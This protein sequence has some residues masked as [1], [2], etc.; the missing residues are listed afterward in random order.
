MRFEKLDCWPECF[1]SYT[2]AVHKMCIYRNRKMSTTAPPKR[3]MSGDD[4]MLTI[5][6][7]ALAVE[8]VVE[9]TDD[10]SGCVICPNPGI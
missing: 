7:A 1:P 3:R 4:K 2:L 9:L 6:E 10:A 5:P 8:P